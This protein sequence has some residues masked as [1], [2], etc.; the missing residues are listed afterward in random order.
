MN[1]RQRQTIEQVAARLKKPHAGA[2]PRHLFRD[3]INKAIELL[4]ANGYE[5]TSRIYLDTWVIPPLELMLSAS[6]L[7]QKTA[8]SL[9]RP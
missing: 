4:Q 5:V 8:L 9:S 6:A 3:D 7:D 2:A 1:K